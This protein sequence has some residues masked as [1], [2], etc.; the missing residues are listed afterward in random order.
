MILTV[1]INSNTCLLCLFCKAAFTFTFSNTPFSSPHLTFFWNWKIMFSYFFELKNYILLLKKKTT[2]VWTHAQN[3]SEGVRLLCT[4]WS[5][6]KDCYEIK[7]C[8]SGINQ[9]NNRIFKNVWPILPHRYI[10]EAVDC[11]SILAVLW[12]RRW[13]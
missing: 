7:V 12:Q 1:G 5:A 10:R 11:L 9:V 8:Q 2:H 4:F 3:I 6:N 13:A